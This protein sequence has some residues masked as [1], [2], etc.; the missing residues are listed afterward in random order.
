TQTPPAALPQQDAAW[1]SSALGS[2][3]QPV[4]PAP[5]PQAAPVQPQAD[6]SFP[7]AS[8]PTEPPVYPQQP[9]QVPHPG[10]QP[11][12]ALAGAP[13]Q[14]EDASFLGEPELELV[15]EEEVEAETKSRK[16]PLL[17][18]GIVGLLAV[19][20]LLG[21]WMVLGGSSGEGGLSSGFSTSDPVLDP[22]DPRSRK[23]DRLPNNF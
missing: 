20:L 14:A 7:D 23:A 5:Q 10:A 9:G 1:P 16:S 2:P 3:G 21:L 19:V 15:E 13:I 8:F 12:P 4:P 17:K 18:W 22:D 6:A 11:D